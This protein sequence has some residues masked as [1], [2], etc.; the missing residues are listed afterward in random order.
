MGSSGVKGVSPKDRNGI[1]AEECSTVSIVTEYPGTPSTKQT[2][3]ELR[4]EEIHRIYATH[5]PGH[6]LH[7]SL[8]LTTDINRVK[9]NRTQTAR[10][11]RN[12][13]PTRDD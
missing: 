4:Y 11:A 7:F 12:G 8:G 6:K 1:R 10:V 3:D 13:T 2:P 9:H 5:Q